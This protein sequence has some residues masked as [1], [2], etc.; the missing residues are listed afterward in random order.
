MFLIMNRSEIYRLL[1]TMKKHN[2]HRVLGL[3][4]A[5]GKSKGLPRKNV[6]PVGGK[7]LLAWTIEAG[8]EASSID[9][10]VL[11]SDDDEIMKV[12]I[13][14]GCDVPFRRP[15]HLA[16][17]EA[18]SIQVVLHA[19]E[20]LPDY[21]FVVLLQ[22]TSPQR[23]SEDIDNAFKLMLAQKQKGRVLKK[24]LKSKK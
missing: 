18:G 23:S 9:R 16:S 5:R 24:A 8:L 12:A 2:P 19:L 11:S 17:D 1:S 4:T 10:L 3:I 6:L 21:D 22:P 20:I 15:D 7:P 13:E 14:Y